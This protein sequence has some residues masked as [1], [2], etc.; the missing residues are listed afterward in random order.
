MKTGGFSTRVDASFT[1]PTGTTQ[2]TAGDQVADSASAP[3]VITFS[4]V[5]R[6][7]GGTGWIVDALCI[8]SANQATK[9]NFRLYLF[10]TAPTPNN[11]NAAWA[12]SDAEMATLLAEI[13]F[14][15]WIIGKADSGADGNCASFIA[16]IAVPFVCAKDSKDIYGLLVER[17][18]YTP[19]SAESWTFRLGVTQD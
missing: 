9:P 11:D 2:Y 18:T 8:D 14:A 13:D 5:A 6:T 12:P 3:T 15:T 19:I 7:E 10:D 17:S 16:N 4:D 1:R